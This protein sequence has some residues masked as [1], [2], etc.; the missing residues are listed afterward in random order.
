MAKTDHEFRDPIHGFIHMSNDELRVVD[1]PPFQRL[2]HIR[3]LALSNLVYPGATHTRFDHSLGVMELA[4]RVFDVVTKEDNLH[5]EVRNEFSEE[6]T[7][8]KKALWRSHLRFAALCHDLG[9]LPFSHAGE[10]LLPKGWEKHDSIS[11]ALTIHPKE[12]MS[13]AWDEIRGIDVEL[14][15]QL[16]VGFKP[17]I[18]GVLEKFPKDSDDP[19][20]Q[21]LSKIITDDAFGVD[22]MDYLLRDAYYTGVSNGVFDYRQLIESLRILPKTQDSDGGSRELALGV[23]FGG[24]P[25]AEAMAVARHIMYRQVYY[26]RTR[27]IYDFHLKQFLREWLPHGKFAVDPKSHLGLTDIHVWAAIMDAAQD[28]NK[29]GH[30]PARRIVERDLFECVYEYWP[31]AEHFADIVREAKENFSGDFACGKIVEVPEVTDLDKEIAEISSANKELDEMDFP[32]LLKG[33]MLRPSGSVSEVLKKI[34]PPLSAMC[35][36]NRTSRRWT[37]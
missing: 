15:A 19:W 10:G 30:T 21:T 26:H 8:N 33:G 32:V 31:Q 24:L 36:S 12:G 3:Q 18:W 1:S 4:G 11:A 34:R 6:L 16:A 37:K 14:I 13:S 17:K 20:V 2:R 7:P 9:H 27:K 28:E 22:R 35:S 23:N 5:E 29:R 25:T